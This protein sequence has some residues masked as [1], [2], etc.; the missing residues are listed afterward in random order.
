MEA[1]CED[2][3]PFEQVIRDVGRRQAPDA[4]I[5][6][7]Q[8]QQALLELNARGLL[9]IY[10]LDAEPPYLS[11]VDADPATIRRYWFTLTGKGQ[12]ALRASRRKSR[13]PTGG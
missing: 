2:I 9:G 7:D 1:V 3:L 8:I 12:K 5:D 13:K 11:P 6:E 4:Q 10:V